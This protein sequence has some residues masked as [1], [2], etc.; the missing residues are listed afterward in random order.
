LI[1]MFDAYF[2]ASDGEGFQTLS[3]RDMLRRIIL[4]I[5]DSFDFC[6]NMSHVGFKE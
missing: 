2:K 6:D 3:R 4:C 5:D 1:S